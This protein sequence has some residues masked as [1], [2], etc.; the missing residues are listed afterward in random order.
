MAPRSEL[1]AGTAAGPDPLDWKGTARFEVIRRIGQGG[2]GVVYEARDREEHRR[3]ALKTLVHFNPA[4]L[5]LFKQ[6]F[7]TLTGVTHPN[8]VRLYEL[9]AT[10]DG[11]VFFAMELVRGVDFAVHVARSPAAQRDEAPSGVSSVESP[12]P[13]SPDELRSGTRPTSPTTTNST[14][15]EPAHTT[16]PAD[17]DRLRPALRQLVEGVLALHAAGKLHRD[18]KPSNVLVTHEGRVVLLDFGV[19][20]ELRQASDAAQRD[21]GQ[22]VGTARYMAPE[23]AFDDPPTPA[24]DWYSVGVMLYEALTGAPPF[25]GATVDVIA[26]KYSLDPRPPCECVEGVPADLDAL[27]RALLDRVPERRP[28]GADILRRLGVEP[29]SLRPMAAAAAESAT[30]LVGRENQ[31][32]AL[33]DAF[34]AAP[35]GPVDHSARERPRRNGQVGPHRALPRRARSRAATRWSSAAA[36]TNASR[37][38]TRPSTASSTRSAAISCTSSTAN[39]PSR[40]PAT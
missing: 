14:E 16:T 32:R 37:S 28:N 19:A 1:Q 36:R 31:A 24:A 13:S 7:R 27:C 29:A 22:M 39:R 40:C 30:S 20:T 2:M 21:E 9:V 23:Q 15:G 8:L 25:H 33:A 5:Y 18:I 3:V 38:H 34:R 17:I 6:E 11:R 10:G 4:S 12:D 26:M 35:C